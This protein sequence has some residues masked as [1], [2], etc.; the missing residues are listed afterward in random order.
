MLERFKK[1]FLYTNAPQFYGKTSARTFQHAVKKDITD[2]T[3][4]IYA[5]AGTPHPSNGILKYHLIAVAE[6]EDKVI[7]FFDGPT[8]R[9][10][11]TTEEREELQQ[12][13][14]GKLFTYKQV[15]AD[16]LLALKG[17]WPQESLHP[18]P[19]IVSQKE[20]E[21]YKRDIIAHMFDSES[22]PIDEQLCDGLSGL[23][24][25]DCFE[26]DLLIFDE[27]DGWYR[28]ISL[29]WLASVLDAQYPYFDI[30]HEK[31]MYMETLDREG[32]KMLADPNGLLARYLDMR[33]AVQGHEV[34]NV[35][36]RS[37][38][39]TTEHIDVYAK[40][41]E[42]GQCSL[43]TDSPCVDVEE[44]Y[45]GEDSA[46]DTLADK[47]TSASFEDEGD[48]GL[49]IDR[50]GV[51]SIRDQNTGELLWTLQET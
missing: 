4:S 15:K 27:S 8:L 33:A 14:G 16:F 22:I 24:K 10:L 51:L 26:S 35:E 39:N 12:I 41:F 50:A 47:L 38:D 43:C 3:Y 34:V 6:N 1:E 40:A 46:L 49:W 48:V 37:N 5:Y 32:K 17:E 31:K 18:L 13:S 2:N 23:E 29:R 19:G 45:A 30:Q 11:F 36:F 9:K 20:E 44:Y 28:E 25:I 7:R 21:C 42:D